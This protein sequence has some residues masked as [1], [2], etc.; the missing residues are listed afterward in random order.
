[1]TKMKL[2]NL[3]AFTAL[4]SAALF[5]FCRGLY[6]AENDQGQSRFSVF[7][8]EPGARFAE[9]NQAFNL[10]DGTVLVQTRQPVEVHLGSCKL[11]VR[12][13]TA[14]LLNT[15][16]GLGCVTDLCESSDQSVTVTYGDCSLKLRA[17]RQAWFGPT[18]SVVA[19]AIKEEPGRP[20]LV[21]QHQAQGV[22]VVAEFSVYPSSILDTTTLMQEMKE[23]KQ[24]RVRRLYDRI[25]KTSAALTMGH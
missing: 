19:S 11:A 2:S 5:L 13:G 9:S 15:T 4:A 18:E 14:L 7:L 6:A 16:K 3:P 20:V 10:D 17:G 22:G 23:S 8:S 1:M 25:I 12:G 21:R 24:A